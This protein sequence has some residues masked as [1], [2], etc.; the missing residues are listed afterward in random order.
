MGNGGGKRERI[1]GKKKESKHLRDPNWE[2]SV[3]YN[4][5]GN[6]F[7]WTDRQYYL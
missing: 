4:V 3:D 7:D 5:C 2:K 6:V 1:K